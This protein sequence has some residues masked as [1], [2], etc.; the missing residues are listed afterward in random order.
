M[1][2]QS[3]KIVKK[4]KNEPPS[5]DDGDYMDIVMINAIL[6][7]LFT[8]FS[9]MVRL[10]IQ[11]GDPLLKQHSIAKGE[12]SALISMK[13]DGV[14][15]SVALSL[16]LPAIR[17]ISKNMMDY[18]ISSIDNEASDLAGELVNMLVGGAKRILSEKG[19]DFDMHTPQML[20]GDGHEIIHHHP[21]RTVLLPV[22]TGEEEFYI[23][24]SFA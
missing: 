16:S 2:S 17:L 11:P 18:E 3:E 5:L 6:A 19:Y 4:R 20:M 13:A 14:H 15:G 10:K 23:E 24:L 7:S 9:T 1:K 12:V 21:E 8:I 22:K